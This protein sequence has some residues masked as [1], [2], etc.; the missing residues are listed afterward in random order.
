MRIHLRI[1]LLLSILAAILP[2]SSW[3]DPLIARQGVD[4]LLKLE[5]DKAETKFA[6]L[7]KQNPD[8]ALLGFL[9]A[10]VYWVKA[11]ASQGG[12][13]KAAWSQAEKRLE[14]AIDE[15]KEA[16]EENPRDPLWRLNLGMSQFFLG[17]VQVEMKR[18]FK[19]IR[20]ARAGRDVLRDLI[21]EHPDMEDAYFVLGM[22]EYIAGSVPR[23]L[24]WLTH[25]FDISGDRALGVKYLERATSRARVMAPEAARMLLAAAGLQPE[26]VEPC[27]YLSLSRQTV[28][29]YPENP[30]YSG[31]NQ[32][33]L[34]HCGF[35]KEALVE[36]KRAFDAFLERFPD[37]VNPLNLVKLQVYPAIGAIDKIEEMAPL[38]TKRDHSHWYL[39]K[40]QAYDVLGQRK[41]AVKIYEEIIYAADNP[42]DPSILGEIPP[43][44]VVEKAELYY[45]H[46]YLRPEPVTI[47]NNMMLGLNDPTKP[48]EPI[49]PDSK[50]PIS[51]DSP[52]G[53]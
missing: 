38:F 8:Y 18:L 14:Q 47:D 37:M 28:K 42:D 33:I 46:P 17:R 16:L 41:K 45:K 10:S 2:V 35:P 51:P 53:W 5:F 3:A 23:G 40:G 21:K 31:A 24:K 34:V 49:V 48:L 50:K 29:L 26:Y 7:R 9:Q 30:H 20:Y 39:A 43:D 22:Y 11:E 15:A 32:L 1:F 13:R 44:F 25:L 19:T 6:Q 27:R 12:E 52:I 36:N 4:H